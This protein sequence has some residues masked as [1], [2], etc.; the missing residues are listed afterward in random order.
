M[1]N[2]A[3]MVLLIGGVYLWGPVGI[4]YVSVAGFVLTIGFKVL[5]IVLKV[6]IAVLNWFEPVGVDSQELVVPDI[7]PDI[8]DSAN[9]TV[10]SFAA[11]FKSAGYSVQVV[12]DRTG[13]VYPIEEVGV[14]VGS[15]MRDITP[16]IRQIR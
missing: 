2:L 3:A 6:I 1:T 9:R 11:M 12:C 8:R 7:D 5:E 13:R 15:G 14:N 16:Q 10:Q 4:V